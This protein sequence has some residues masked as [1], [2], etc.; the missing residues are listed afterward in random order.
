M[1][2]EK[3]HPDKQATARPRSE[4]SSPAYNLADCLQVADLIHKRGGG[5]ATAE[6][7]SSYLGYKSTNNGSYLARMGAARAFGLVGKAGNYF[8]PTPLALQILTPVY[9]TDAKRALVDAFFNVPLFKRVYDDFKGK[10]LPPEFGMKNALRQQYGVIPNR[11]GLAYRIL[12]ESAEQ[13]GFFETRNGAKTHLI[14]PAFPVG[15]ATTTRT[16]DDR[17]GAADNSGGG[18][19]GGGD[20]TNDLGNASASTGA[21]HANGSSITAAR[22]PQLAEVKAQYLQTL[23][24]LFEEKSADGELDEKLMERIERLL[25]ATA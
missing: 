25:G 24:K 11:I 1:A 12:M 16:A 2:V 18:N 4:L 6:H 8:V 22:S 9:Q 20:G 3:L 19:S 10:E 13:S 17:S 14:L 5:T 21:G 7:L 23:I 15:A